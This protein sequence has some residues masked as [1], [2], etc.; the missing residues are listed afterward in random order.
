[1]SMYKGTIQSQDR[2]PTEL[3]QGFTY[4]L[5][6]GTVHEHFLHPVH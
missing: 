3:Y 4:S 5:Y 6:R 1:M 2:T